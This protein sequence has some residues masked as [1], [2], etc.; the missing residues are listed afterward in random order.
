VYFTSASQHQHNS[1]GFILADLELRPIYANDAALQ[2]LD[3]SNEPA[4]THEWRMLV[5]KRLQFILKAQR[6]D[7]ISRTSAPFVSGR[8]QYFCRCFLLD[9]RG[10][11]MGSPLVAVLMERPPLQHGTL[12]EASRRYH[13]SSREYETVLHLTHGLT[14]KEIAQRMNVSPNTVKQFVRLIMSK[15][16]V[17]TRSGIVGKLLA[18]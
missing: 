10:D 11:E 6:Y 2:I 17:T 15:M 7:E 16:S 18:S 12:P 5:Q 13:L 14:T 1:T 8:R 3:Y 9:A 4:V